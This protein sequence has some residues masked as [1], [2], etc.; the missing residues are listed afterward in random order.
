LSITV[1]VASKL[2]LAICRALHVNRLTQ[3]LTHVKRITREPFGDFWQPRTKNWSC[4]V[5]CL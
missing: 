3:N 1:N 2:E 5:F 4:I